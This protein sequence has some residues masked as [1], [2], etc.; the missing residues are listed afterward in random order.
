MHLAFLWRDSKL[1]SI[2]QTPVLF[3]KLDTAKMHGLDTSSRAVP[4]RDEPSGIWAFVFP[5]VR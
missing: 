1:W 5:Y 4:G 2:A 3:D